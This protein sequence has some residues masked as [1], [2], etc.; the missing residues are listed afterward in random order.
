MIVLLPIIIGFVM[1]GF[2]LWMLVDLTNNKYLTR[3]TKNN[4]FIAFI[5][6]N[7]FGALWYYMVEYRNRNL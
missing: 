6:L 2:W 7:I 3:E 5:F 1:V 4:W